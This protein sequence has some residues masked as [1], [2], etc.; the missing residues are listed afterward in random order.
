MQIVL[1]QLDMTA[2]GEHYKF[3]SQVDASEAKGI[4]ACHGAH[5]RAVVGESVTVTMSLCD[6]VASN[7]REA[8]AGLPGNPKT[9]MHLVRH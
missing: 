2:P 7:F 8:H 6:A 3:S 5:S 9:W 1:S 4:F